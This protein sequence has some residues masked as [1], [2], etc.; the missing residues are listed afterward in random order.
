MYN[1]SVFDFYWKDK[2][3]INSTLYFSLLIISYFYCISRI[4]LLIFTIFSER[5]WLLACVLLYLFPW[6]CSSVYLHCVNCLL[7]SKHLEVLREYIILL[8]IEIVCGIVLYWKISPFKNSN[9]LAMITLA[10]LWVETTCFYLSVSQKLTY[11]NHSPL[12]K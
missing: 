3:R 8:C 11:I 1:I 4:Y 10:T 5:Y 9:I 12:K 2:R 7:F 6:P